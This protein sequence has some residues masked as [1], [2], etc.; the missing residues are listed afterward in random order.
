[1]P[2]KDRRCE[3]CNRRL[4]HR[5][6]A[7]CSAECGKR[8]GR[9]RRNPVAATHSWHVEPT[10][11]ERLVAARQA[12]GLTQAELACLTGIPPSTIAEYELGKTP[13]VERA[14][15]LER[16]LGAEGIEGHARAG[17]LARRRER[18]ERIAGRRN[19]ASS[20]A[21]I[22]RLRHGWTLEECARQAGVHA[23]TVQRIERGKP[24]RWPMLR[25]VGAALDVDL[26]PLAAYYRCRIEGLSPAT[27]YGGAVRAARYR[28]G[29]EREE[30][31]ALL[32]LAP[33]S[34]A[35]IELDI[36]R[37]SPAVRA[38][39]EAVLGVPADW[40]PTQGGAA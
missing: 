18:L 24:V 20:L 34:V 12:R 23:K 19:D 9:A 3:Y 22:E 1:M 36:K 39:I 26:V 25:R 11:T 15:L 30:L 38:R 4:G 16:V 29:L 5:R 31:S 40:Q 13:S 37:T 35:N 8:S 33:N 10:I 28:H 7:F 32:D 2:G 21:Q 27:T 17:R 6:V 14:R